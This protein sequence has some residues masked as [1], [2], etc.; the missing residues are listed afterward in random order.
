MCKKRKSGFTLIELLVVIAIIGILAAILLPALARAREA[1]RRASCANNLKQW[2]LITKMYANESKG[3]FPPGVTSVPV[4]AGGWVFGWMQGISGESIYPDYWNDPKIA[5]CPSDSRA[6]YNPLDANSAGFGVEDDYTAQIQRLGQLATQTGTQLCLNAYLS[7]PASYLYI[8][9]AA[10]TMSQMLDI[11]HIKGNIAGFGEDWHPIEYRQ[12]G[13]N[14]LANAGCTEFGVARYNR[15][16]IADISGYPLV[17][18][19]PRNYDWT[20]DNF[21]ALPTSYPRL[22][23]GVERFF[24]TDINNPGA[25]TAAASELVVMFDAW[26]DNKTAAGD[27]WGGMPVPANAVSFYN[28]IPGG[29]NVL[30]MDGHVEFVRYQSKMPVESQGTAPEMRTQV[31]VWMYMAGGYG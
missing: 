2:G 15:F 30:Y 20:D 14:L 22:R 3:A 12:H 5:I 16:N 9:Y 13:D 4:S 29:S 26:A 10:Q 7:I 31:G 19:S 17:T 28:H 6:D 18:F 21:E 8:G 27:G 1:A 23:E 24:I 25:A 11:I